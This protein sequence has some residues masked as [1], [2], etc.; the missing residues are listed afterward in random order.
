MVVAI[1]SKWRAVLVLAMLPLV[2]VL[3]CAGEPRQARIL[4][5][6]VWNGTTD[7]RT[8]YGVV[9]GFGDAD[10]TLVW[11]A[12]PFA[13]PPI[14]ELRWRAPRDPAPWNGI[15]AARA[16][17]PGC[18]QFNPLVGGI[19]GS[20]DCLALNVWRPKGAERDLPVYVW[21][22]GGGNSIGSAAMVREYRG[23]RIARISNVVFVSLNYRL[24]PFGW[25][26]HPALREGSSP[27]D[28]SGNFGTLD[29]IQGLKWIRD[30]IAAFGGDPRNVTITG[31][32]SGAMDVLSVLLSPLSKGL[33]SK[34]VSQSAA[35]G[36]RDPAD[37][38]QRAERVLRQLLVNDRKAR[39]IDQAEAVVRSMTAE[40]IRKYLRSKSDRQIVRCFA[41][42]ATGMTDNPAIFRDGHVI[43]A[44]GLDAFSTGEY[45][46]KVPLILGSNREE[47]KLF[48]AF[49]RTRSWKSELSQALARYGSLRWKATGVDSIARRVRESGDAAPVYV[50][51]FAWGAPDAKGESPMPGPWGRR[52]GAFHSLD[53]PFF[54]G[55]DTVDAV[56]YLALFTSGNRPGR[57]GLSSAMMDYVASFVRTGDP[58][59]PDSGLPRW[60]P[61]SNEPGGPKGI[62]FDADRRAPGIAMTGEEVTE[63]GV[64]AAIDRDLPPALA[65][66]TRESLARFHAAPD[67]R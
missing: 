30:N 26:S 37:G 42:G 22:H 58:N 60:Q 14:G 29:I 49:D 32:S 23:N 19:K 35:V 50:Y 39:T 18:T 54:L 28:D 66:Q 38:E 5:P 31:E 12:I 3:S 33:F 7:V 59:R 52:L 6:G 1:D 63:D 21:I 2:L 57:Q 51:E 15:R 24:G 61:W 64:F 47:L 36:T 53:I 20:E 16:F 34:A 43:P 62:I 45:P 13:A 4:E 40:A 44:A 9:R 17:N 10:D 48:L 11:K 8:R 67:S 25:F 56:L 41:A 65:A 27:E 46:N 55:Q